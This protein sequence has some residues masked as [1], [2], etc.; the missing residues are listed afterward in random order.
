MLMCFTQ[1]T[2]KLLIICTN[3][4]MYE[5]LRDKSL[6]PELPEWCNP[7]S[8]RSLADDDAGDRGVAGSVV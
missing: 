4:Q 5:D 6:A 2:V 8:S 1:I 3:K 7:C